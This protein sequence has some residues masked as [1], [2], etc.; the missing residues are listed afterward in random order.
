MSLLEALTFMTL[1][2][3]RVREIIVKM[4]FSH[5]VSITVQFLPHREHSARP[6]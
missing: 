3:Y 6:F 2:L 5:Y 4:I 1:D